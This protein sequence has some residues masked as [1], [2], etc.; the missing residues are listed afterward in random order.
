MLATIAFTPTAVVVADANVVYQNQPS[1]VSITGVVDIG[2]HT[3]TR[4]FFFARLR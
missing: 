1:T 3:K 2:P 4:L